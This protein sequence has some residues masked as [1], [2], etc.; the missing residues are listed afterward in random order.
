[1]KVKTKQGQWLGD[2]V[3]RETGNLQKLVETAVLND[4]SMTEN[5]APGTEILCL[6]PPKS[7][8]VAD[9]YRAKGIYPATAME[10]APGTP[11]GIGYMA[12]GIT[13]IVS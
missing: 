2:V 6:S 4:I 7:D 3:I 13:F 10:R 8:S 11:G 5:I 1:M 9:H 12:V